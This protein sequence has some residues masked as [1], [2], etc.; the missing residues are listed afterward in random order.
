M[1]IIGVVTTSRADFGLYRPVLR[2]MAG[3]GDLRPAIFATGMHLS[4][5]FGMTVNRIEEEGFEIAERVEML[6]HTHVRL[7][8]CDVEPCIGELGLT[9]RAREIPTIVLDRGHADDR[10]PCEAGWDEFHLRNRCPSTG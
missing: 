8:P 9:P 5:E 3:T 1:R 4:P 10:H 2:A 6:A 7:D